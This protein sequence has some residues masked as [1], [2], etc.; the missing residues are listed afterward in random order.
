[1]ELV[2]IEISTPKNTETAIS[3]CGIGYMNVK[4]HFYQMGIVLSNIW[5]SGLHSANAQVENQT[6]QRQWTRLAKLKFI[7]STMYKL[8]LEMH[9]VYSFS[10][11]IQ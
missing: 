2:S 11:H 3:T 1:M 10:S 9:L 8:G 7:A 5:P 4:M 6:I